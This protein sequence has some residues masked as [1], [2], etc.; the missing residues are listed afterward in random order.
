MNQNQFDEIIDSVEMHSFDVAIITE[1]IKPIKFNVNSILR[2]MRPNFHMYFDTTGESTKKLVS[3]FRMVE[4]VRFSSRPIIVTNR[5][6]SMKN[7]DP[8][9]MPQPSYS[10]VEYCVAGIKP[11]ECQCTD[12]IDN[13]D[14]GKNPFDSKFVLSNILKR[15]APDF[16]NIITIGVMDYVTKSTVESKYINT[17]CIFC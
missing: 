2:I 13:D 4:S 8:Q 15:S 5:S 10:V 9:M 6:N 7:E 1:T 16:S 17:T 12:F 14:R 3:E 11:L